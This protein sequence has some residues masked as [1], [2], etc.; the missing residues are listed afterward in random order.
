MA[1][2]IMGAGLWGMIGETDSDTRPS[3]ATAPPEFSASSADIDLLEDRSEDLG[4]N[5][6]TGEE[7]V[8]TLRTDFDQWSEGAAELWPNPLSQDL[9]DGTATHR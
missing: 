4:A 1:S 6:S 3:K 5:W 7:E 8:A 2:I 9:Q